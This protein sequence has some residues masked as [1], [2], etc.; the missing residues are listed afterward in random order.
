MRT[1]RRAPFLLLALLALAGCGRDGAAEGSLDAA[2]GYFPASAGSVFAISTDLDSDQVKALDAQLAP[3]LLGGKVKESLRALVEGDDSG[4]SFEDDVEPLLGNRLVVGAPEPH[5]L[6]AGLFTDVADTSFLAAIEV[7]DGDALREVL[8]K[9]DGLDE[10]GDA[11]GAQLYGTE[12]D[13]STAV[14]GD[15]LVLA[16]DEQHLRAALAQPDRRD[17]LTEERFEA[18]LEGLAD[19]ALVRGYGDL[20]GLLDVPSLARFGKIPWVASLRT[21]GATASFERGHVALDLALNTDPQTIDDADLPFEPGP[22]APELVLRDGQ[23]SGASR[24]QSQTTVFLLR[25]VRAAYP[26]SRFVRDVATI[27]RERGIDFEREVLQQFNG[28][29]ASLLGPDGSFAARSAVRDPEFIAR[30]MRVLAPDLGRLI[31]DLEGLRTQGMA[32]LLLFAPDAPVSP[33][34]GR[35]RVEVEEIRRDFYRVSGLTG[36]GPPV[37]VFG[38]VGDVFVVASDERRARAIARADAQPA[39]GLR[40]ASVTSSDAAPLLRLIADFIPLPPDLL[41]RVSGSFEASRERLRG[42]LRINLP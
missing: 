28:P 2:L 40:G 21:F 39:D 23:I 7:T 15:V 30:R 1:L 32:L 17:R 26:D 41:D 38:L 16:D 11:S 5:G 42:R 34:L 36:D 9:L 18:A 8:G 33:V 4:I 37:L 6:A 19:E 22:E 3:A 13:A 35:S 27:E 24:N 25:A 12:G 29:S 20:R 31:Q 10:V 14:D